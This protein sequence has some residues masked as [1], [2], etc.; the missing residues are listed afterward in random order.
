MVGRTAGLYVVI[1]AVNKP[2]RLKT[3][4]TSSALSTYHS[5]VSL[6]F[7]R[8]ISLGREASGR[9][10]VGGG[11]GGE[12]AAAGAREHLQYLSE[13]SQGQIEMTCMRWSCHG[14]VG[15]YTKRELRQLYTQHAIPQLDL[16]ALA[17]GKCEENVSPTTPEKLLEAFERNFSRLPGNFRFT[18]ACTLS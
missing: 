17:R 1:R 16:S 9:E 10:R 7:S 18:L 2:V 13:P 6:P 4:R 5:S 14:P 15:V 12:E 3:I 8:A 11:G